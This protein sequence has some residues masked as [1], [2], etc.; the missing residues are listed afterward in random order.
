[1][2]IS[3]KIQSAMTRASW[4]RRM[5]EEGIKL[6]ARYGA[7]NVFDFSL[8]NPILEPPDVVLQVLRE[9]VL[10]PHPGSHRYMPNNGYPEVRQTIA[11][12]F[13]ARSAVPVEAG[14]VVMTVG[15]AGAL[16]VTLKA[17]LEPGD[18]VIVITPFFPEYEFYVDNHQ[19]V[20]VKVPSTET[21]DVDVTAIER[22]LTP[23]TKALIVNNPN[24]PTGCVYT[25]ERL[26]E[27]GAVLQEHEKKV[28]HPVTVL[29]DEPYRKIVF[30]DVVVPDIFAIHDNV[31][32]ITSHS[33]DLGL[34]GERIGYAIVSPN[35]VDRT[36]LVSAMTFVNRTLGYINAPAIFQRVAAAAIEASVPIE[37]Y[38]QLRDTLCQGL[39]EAGLEFQQP[40]GA[41][42]VFPKSP[43]PD[44]DFVRRLMEHRILAVPG[45][46]FACP[47]Y[48][49]LSYC[50]SRREVEQALPLFKEVMRKLKAG[51]RAVV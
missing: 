12:W 35:H 19:G 37:T 5:F 44:V 27:L 8:G 32:F 49:R 34:A 3:S 2:S 23:R 30:D 7:E 16:N 22:A 13:A 20:L 25:L 31:V 48:F 1:V 46:G 33:K 38:K 41:F 43:E 6:R 24:N 28:G 18:E 45:S 14:D 36:E 11:A 10:E 21:F 50:V 51:D 26:R 47:G 40:K 39:T 42:Y 4:I 17:L 15:A 29:S 9:W